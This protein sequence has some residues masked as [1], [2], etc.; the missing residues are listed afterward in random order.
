M[1]TIKAILV[2]IDV[3]RG[4]Q[5]VLDYGR[6]LAGAL[7]ARRHV[8]HVAGNIAAE[9]TAIGDCPSSGPG[10]QRQF[11]HPTKLRLESGLARLARR[12]HHATT[13]LVT[14]MQP[15]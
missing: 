12:R 4:S 11:N 7:D 14:S 13:S 5:A 1:S 10:P 9:G 15:G 8:V 3:D 2:T 6:L